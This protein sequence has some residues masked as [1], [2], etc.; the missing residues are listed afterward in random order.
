MFAVIRDAKFSWERWW[1]N[2]LVLASPDEIMNNIVSRGFSPA[3]AAHGSVVI[4]IDAS[5]DVR[6]GQ[7]AI[8]VVIDK[9]CL[10]GVA[11]YGL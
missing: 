4:S 8:S 11:R 6:S 7:G 10:W 5:F 9:I 1:Q 3:A 2:L